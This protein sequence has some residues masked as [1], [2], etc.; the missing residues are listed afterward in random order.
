MGKHLLSV[1]QGEGHNSVYSTLSS[2][3]KVKAVPAPG[4]NIQHNKIWMGV[5]SM[6]SKRGHKQYESDRVVVHPAA[7]I[8]NLDILK[9]VTAMSEVKLVLWFINGFGYSFTGLLGISWV[10]PLLKIDDLGF[11]GWKSHL[12]FILLLIFWTQKIVFGIAKNIQDYRNRQL[13]LKKKDHDITK[14]LED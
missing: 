5:D 10:I 9:R 2:G 13:S 14:E 6:D 3:E 11:D 1:G 8:N 4:G 7:F 12:I